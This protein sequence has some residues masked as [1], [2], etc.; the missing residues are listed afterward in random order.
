M[1]KNRK[2]LHNEI[3]QQILFQGTSQT[4]QEIL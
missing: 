3:H 2:P 1:I 4:P